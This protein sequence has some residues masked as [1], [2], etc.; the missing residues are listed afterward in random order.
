MVLLSFL[1]AGCGPAAPPQSPSAP[2]LLLREPDAGG[3]RWVEETLS[4]LTLREAIGQ[5]IVP[6]M[7]GAYTSTTGPEFQEFARYV[8]EAGIGG[9]VISIGLPH[10]YGAKLNAL[11]A[12]ARIP[13]LVSSDFENG[14]PGMRIN[15]S[16]ALP[17][18]L[19]Q[20][21]GHL[22]SPDDGLRSHR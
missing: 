21:G 13:L 2:A 8:E 4:S 3:R 18:L 7:S 20:G 22:L 16:Y 15:H 9:V 5:L 14:G 19:P 17:T 11:Q 1:G 10:T 6:W 12:R